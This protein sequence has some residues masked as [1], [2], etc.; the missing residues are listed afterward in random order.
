MLIDN[1]PRLFVWGSCDLRDIVDCEIISKN[2]ELDHD[3]K[4]V[5][6]FRSLNSSDPSFRFPTATT[7][8]SAYET[9]S[10]IADRVDESLHVASK[11]RRLKAYHYQIHKEICKFPH[12]DYFRKYSTNNDILVINFSSELYTRYISPINKF[13]LIPPMMELAKMDDPLHWLYKEYLIKSEHHMSFDTKEIQL[14]T[15]DYLK[16]FIKDI[17]EIF[18]D[19]VILVKTHLT[20]LS[21]SDETLSVNRHLINCN[22]HIPFYKQTRIMTSPIDHS[23]A[24]KMASHILR[25]FVH[26][27]KEDIP[28]VQADSPVFMDVNH[29]WGASPFHLHKKTNSRLAEQLN[30]CILKIVEKQ[31]LSSLQLSGGEASIGP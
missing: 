29:K 13:T 8:L 25:K 16:D 14:M 3:I 24:D 30:S 4:N 2:Y 12:I 10:S 31:R 26:V 23:Y 9:I 19:R 5:S 20:N 27:Y 7:L 1:K 11:T 17:H 18:K 6:S 28:I 15:Y 21:Y 22:T